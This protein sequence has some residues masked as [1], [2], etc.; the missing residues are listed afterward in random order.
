MSE[1]VEVVVGIVG[2][3]HGI[4]GEVSVELRTDEPGRRFVPGA[5]LRPEGGGAELTV[6]AV[7][8]H[9]GRL[10]VRFAEHPDR[11]AAEGLRGTVLMAEVDAA[12]RPADAEEYYDR[13]LIGLRVLTAGDAVAGT[14]VEVVHLPSQDLLEIRTETGLR[15]V[16]FV[17]ALVPEVDLTTGALRLAD[18]PGLLADLDDPADDPVD[19]AASESTIAPGAGT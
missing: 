17:R 9:G 18:V 4:R 10:L 6:A 2:R 7:R 8:D 14:V 13:Q 5:V 11:S 1:T 16:P 19:Q 12:E 3:A 15:M